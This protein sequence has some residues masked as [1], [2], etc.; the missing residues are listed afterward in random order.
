MLQQPSRADFEKSIVSSAIGL[1]TVPLNRV[2]AAGFSAKGMSNTGS[3]SR[4]NKDPTS[5]L[6]LGLPINCKEAK[7]L[8]EVIDSIRYDTNRKDWS[9]ALNSCKI[10]GGIVS[11]KR[12]E[13]L[14]AVR[15]EE[16]AKGEALLQELL[17]ELIPLEKSL[18]SKEGTGTVQERIKLDESYNA[19]NTLSNTV[20]SLL[21]LMVPSDY[22][23]KLEAAIPS[24]FDQ[25]PRLLGRAK[26]EFTFEKPEKGQKF[27]VEGTLYDQAKLVMVVDGYTTPITSGCFVDLVEKNFYQN[28]IVTRSDGFV[29]QMGDP[30]PDGPK[31][32]YK[33]RIVP[34]EIFVSGDSVPTYSITT[35]DDERGYASTVLPFQAYGALGMAR[36]E[37]EADSASSQFF[38]LLFESDL[39]PAGKN[40]LDGRYTEF[41]YTIENAELLK[42][43]KEGDVIV[44]AKVLEG[45]QYLK[46][47]K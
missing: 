3:G 36:S 20:G 18:S 45:K 15:V 31:D 34:L 8:A 35:E 29:V 13:L 33:D 25:L 9:R 28:L 44:S 30:E 23:D 39:T 10:A 43:V 5:L 12:K 7:Y 6:R 16:R 40:L 21:E 27:D 22:I 1:A 26:V 46:K 24:E 2:E 4:V 14:N 11:K 19:Q 41:G 42:D 47:S 37:F 38:F 17:D 32:G